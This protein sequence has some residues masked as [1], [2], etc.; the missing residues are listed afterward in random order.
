MITYESLTPVGRAFMYKR[1]RGTTGHLY[2]KM[3]AWPAQSVCLVLF[4]LRSAHFLLLNSDYNRVCARQVDGRGNK[5]P[6][7][8]IQSESHY[9]S[10][11][12]VQDVYI[13]LYYQVA[14]SF[15]QFLYAHNLFFF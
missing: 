10:Y 7:G 4:S 1:L 11:L 12:R 2:I 14:I 15:F 5:V 6:G 8:A 13:C 3:A 9:W